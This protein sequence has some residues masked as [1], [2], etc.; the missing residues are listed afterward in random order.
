MKIREADR[1][2]AFRLSAVGLAT[3]LVAMLGWWAVT[4]L[5]LVGAVP[6]DRVAILFALAALFAV[7]SATV[8]IFTTGRMMVKWTWVIPVVGLALLVLIAI[9]STG[10]SWT[11]IA[12]LV[13][14]WGPPFLAWALLWRLAATLV[15]PASPSSRGSHR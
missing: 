12:P 2:N 14:F 11:G 9:V 5:I 6:F 13:V 8:V 10:T 4:E 3:L 1:R 15:L 7:L